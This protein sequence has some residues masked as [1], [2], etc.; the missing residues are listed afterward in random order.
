MLFKRN[1]NVVSL[2]LHKLTFSERYSIIF[3]N[4][5]KPKVILLN[6]IYKKGGY[7]NNI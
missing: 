1:G 3:L 2:T 5:D 7:K 6:R 4:S